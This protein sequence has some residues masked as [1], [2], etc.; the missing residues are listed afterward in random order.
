MWIVEGSA[1]SPDKLK[2]IQRLTDAERTMLVKIAISERNEGKLT[3][4]HID[5][6]CQLLLSIKQKR[7]W[8]ACSCMMQPPTVMTV[9]QRDL[10]VYLRRVS[11][12]SEHDKKCPFYREQVDNDY[13]GESARPTKNSLFSLYKTSST[14]SRPSVSITTQASQGSSNPLPKLGSCLYRLLEAQH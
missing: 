8:L 4:A 3:K 12:F 1:Q 7:Q 5:G 2:N 10:S 14:V 11:R 6:A 13:L 9:C